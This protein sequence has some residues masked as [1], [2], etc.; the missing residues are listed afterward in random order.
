MHG[1]VWINTGEE[2]VGGYIDIILNTERDFFEYKKF[3]LEPTVS[4]QKAVKAVAQ[5][6]GKIQVNL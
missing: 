2:F 1:G 4:A 3:Y 5:A 6:G